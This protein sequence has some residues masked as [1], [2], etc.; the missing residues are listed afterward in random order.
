MGRSGRSCVWFSTSR[1]R[2]TNTRLCRNLPGLGCRRR[3][4]RIDL[5]L[6]L[7]PGVMKLINL[8]IFCGE[9]R[10]YE[11]NLHDM[12]CHIH[13][14]I[15][16]WTAKGNVTFFCA[17]KSLWIIKKNEVACC[18]CINA[19]YLIKFGTIIFAE[20]KQPLK[21]SS[22]HPLG[23]YKAEICLSLLIRTILA[24]HWKLDLQ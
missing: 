3:P 5:R 7:P 10:E 1:C 24:F 6:H 11:G 14:N 21:L 18:V 12:W 16:K 20:K 22:F 4:C 19:R 15:N 13:I 8:S 23:P 9:N 17:W 2:P